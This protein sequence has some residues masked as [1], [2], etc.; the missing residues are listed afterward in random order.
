MTT[1]YVTYA[2]AA[3][4]RFDRDYNIRNHLP[5]ATQ[6]WG[7][8]GLESCTAFWRA[9]MARGMISIAMAEC[10]FP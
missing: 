7:P 3:D 2:A 8:L 4:T 5:L 9:G 1:M 10:R 6:C